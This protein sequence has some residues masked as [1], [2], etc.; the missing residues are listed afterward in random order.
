M[1]APRPP[2]TQFFAP[3]GGGGGGDVEAGMLY[4]GAD[5]LDNT[6][7]WGFVRKVRASC[8]HSTLPRTAGLAVGNA[9]C[10]A[11]CL[12]TVPALS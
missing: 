4:P 7:R 2:S 8:S 5:A 6:L 10:P 12:A 1:L 11:C 3:F 9:A